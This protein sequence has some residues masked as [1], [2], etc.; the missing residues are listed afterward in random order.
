[1]LKAESRL[2]DGTAAAAPKSVPGQNT[3]RITQRQRCKQA[4]TAKPRRR[5]SPERWG[6]LRA[7]LVKEHAALPPD[8]PRKRPTLAKLRLREPA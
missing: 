5:I 2:A 7:A 4:A 6:S 1:M 3:F 8:S